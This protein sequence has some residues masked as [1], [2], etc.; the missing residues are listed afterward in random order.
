[1]KDVKT[2]IQQA[3]VKA[4]LSVN[5]ELI[6]LYWDVG[7][8]YALRGADRQSSPTFRRNSSH[9]IMSATDL[10]SLLLLVPSRD[11][12]AG[13]R[14]MRSEHALRLPEYR[15]KVLRLREGVPRRT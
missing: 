2:Q 4:V 9:F 15:T 7:H 5:A 12:R 10:F 3:Q 6:R 13:A 1:M 11:L 8:A 14:G